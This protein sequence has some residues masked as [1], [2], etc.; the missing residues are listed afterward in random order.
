M[1]IYI[2]E[3]DSLRKRPI[4]IYGTYPL[5]TSKIPFTEI[6]FKLDLII[7]SEIFF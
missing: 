4:D 1:T 7:T 2:N 3:I 6:A 5:E